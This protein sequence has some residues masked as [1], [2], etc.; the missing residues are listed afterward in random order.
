MVEEPSIL[1]QNYIFLIK[2]ESLI[3]I[4]PCCYHS[5]SVKHNNIFCIF[6]TSFL[7]KYHL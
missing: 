2:K 7:T 1:Q 4:S 6:A 5:V 3:N